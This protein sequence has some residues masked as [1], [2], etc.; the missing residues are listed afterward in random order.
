MLQ[1]VDRYT[2]H[3]VDAKETLYAIS[4]K[5]GVTVDEIME[6]NRLENASLKQGQQLRINK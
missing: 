3:T 2:V 1:I 5:Y 6:W 4:K